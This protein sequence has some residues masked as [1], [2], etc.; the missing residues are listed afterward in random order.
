MSGFRMPDFT[1]LVWC[2]VVGIV[3]IVVGGAAALAWLGYVLFLGL[4]VAFS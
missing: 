3:A 4:Q 1:L 2:A